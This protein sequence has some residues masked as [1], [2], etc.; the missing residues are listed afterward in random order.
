MIKVS[1]LFG[2]IFLEVFSA[3]DFEKLVSDH[4]AERRVKGGVTCTC[5]N[6]AGEVH[7]RLDQSASPPGWTNRT[8]RRR[9]F[10]GWNSLISICNDNDLDSSLGDQVS[11]PSKSGFQTVA[12]SGVR[13]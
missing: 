4:G 6:G 12:N 7:V 2:Q 1:S 10:R 13:L 3:V 9:R 5:P 8:R 11:N